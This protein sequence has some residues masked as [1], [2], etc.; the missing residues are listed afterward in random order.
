MLGELS[1]AR[2]LS[3]K[4]ERALAFAT[5]RMVYLNTVRA[6]L[7]ERQLAASGAGPPA[8]KAPYD[9]FSM[10][11]SVGTQVAAAK[12]AA[13]AVDDRA[14]AAHLGVTIKS[15][16]FDL[17]EGR[18]AKSALVSCNMRLVVAIAR[19]YQNLG[20]ALPDL[21]QEGAMGLIRAVEKFDV[22]RGFKVRRERSVERRPAPPLTAARRP[23]PSPRRLPS[24]P[25]T[26]A[27]GSSRPSSGA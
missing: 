16:R 11:Q 1:R 10:A 7:Y 27:G 15:V 14:L 21:I 19:R 4:E 8:E 26:R 3:S 5:K 6:E 20:L 2:L 22:E 23:S 9:R 13:R 25:R 12:A 24:S 18:R 17:G